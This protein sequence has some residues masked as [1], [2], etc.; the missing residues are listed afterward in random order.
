[1]G[2]RGF[3]LAEILGVI[4]IISLLLNNYRPSV[5]N[6]IT[7][8]KGDAASAGEDI[9]FKATDE[10]IS[11]HPEDFPNGKAGRYCITIK[12]LLDEGKLVPTGMRDGKEIYVDSVSGK[13]YTNLSVMVTIYSKWNKGLRD[14]RGR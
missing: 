10:Y 7:G 3:T 1:M 6:R 9:V 12:E 8:T 4:V 11:D 2:K 5:I 14:K 13:D